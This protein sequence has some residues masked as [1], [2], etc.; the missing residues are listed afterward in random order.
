M[1]LLPVPGSNGTRGYRLLDTPDATMA[2]YWDRFILDWSRFGL[3]NH[4]W[5]NTVRWDPEGVLSTTGAICTALLG[6]VAGWWLGKTYGRPEC[7]RGLVV[8]GAATT[9]LGLVWHPVF[10]IN[11]N[12]WTGAYVLF[13]AGLACLLLA[14]I[15]WLVDV[16][17]W[18]GWTTPFVVYGTNPLI[19]FVGSGVLARLIYS[20]IKVDDRGTTRPIQAVIYQSLFASWLSPKNASLAFA[21]AFVLLFLGILWLLHRRNIVLKI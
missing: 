7:V 5:G 8:A 20:V 14:A 19:A 2:A 21:L 15:M 11:K 4:L 9:L 13:T 12:L 1:T 18:R 6:N 17:G 3:G 10:P 16:R